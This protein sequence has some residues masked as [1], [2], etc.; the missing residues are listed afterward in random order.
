MFC[1]PRSELK[2]IKEKKP[3]ITSCFLL[4]VCSL[5]AQ[6]C[7][8]YELKFILLLHKVLTLNAFVII[9]FCSICLLKCISIHYFVIFAVFKVLCIFPAFSIHFTFCPTSPANYTTIKVVVTRE[10]WSVLASRGF[11]LCV[12]VSVCSCVCDFWCVSVHVM[13]GYSMLISDV[14]MIKKVTVWSLLVLQ[15]VYFMYV[16]CTCFRSLVF[17]H[18]G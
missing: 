12:N 14:Y 17:T 1:G 15:G 3:Q 6:L 5:A 2:D 18:Q 16:S 13:G 8:W 10:L 11:D 7:W 4:L 9:T